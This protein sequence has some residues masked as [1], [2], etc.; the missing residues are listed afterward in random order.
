M[1]VVPSLDLEGGRSRLV[2]WPGAATGSGT[3]TDR[4]ERI[5]RHFVEQGAPLVHVVDLD[6]AK[7]GRPVNVAAI[8]AIAR[9][10]ATPLQVAGG[11]DGPEQ[12]EVCFAAGATRVVMPLQAVVEDPAR[13]RACLGVAG[14]WLAIGLDPRADRWRAFPWRAFVPPT[15]DEVVGGLVEAGVRRFLLSH[16]GAAPDLEL[17]SGLVRRHDAEFLLAG[18]VTDLDALQPVRDAGVAGII[19]GEPLISG[20]IDYSAAARSAA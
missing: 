12:I 19:L 6:G 18:G 9:A 11:V 1:Q 2:F 10:V 8:G 3:P 16:G 17:L 5:A 7:Q 20:V 14:D 4:P 15:L 13:L